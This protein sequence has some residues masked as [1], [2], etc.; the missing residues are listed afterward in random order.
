VQLV[1]GDLT[2]FDAV[3]VDNVHRAVMLMDGSQKSRTNA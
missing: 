1:E 2:E 3:G